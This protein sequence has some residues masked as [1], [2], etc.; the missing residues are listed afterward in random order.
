LLSAAFA[1]LDIT[2][3]SKIVLAIVISLPSPR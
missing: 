3:A 1:L 2:S